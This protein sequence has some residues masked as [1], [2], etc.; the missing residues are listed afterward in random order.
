MKRGDPIVERR[1]TNHLAAKTEGD[2][3]GRYGDSRSLFPATDAAYTEEAG[4]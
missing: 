3:T 2:R 1:T 4:R